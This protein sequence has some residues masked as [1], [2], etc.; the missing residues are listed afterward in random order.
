MNGQQLKPYVENESLSLAISL[1]LK[2]V[3]DELDFKEFFFNQ[4]YA[5]I[6]IIPNFV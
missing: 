4:F 2:E 5:K 1:N 6:F 3:G